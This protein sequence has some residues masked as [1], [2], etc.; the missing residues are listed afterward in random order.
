LSSYW[1]QGEALAEPRFRLARKKR[2]RNWM[3]ESKKRSPLHIL[4]GLPIAWTLS[5]KEIGD[6]VTV[7]AP[8]E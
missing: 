3:I 2:I 8:V 4:K 6:V 1:E 5:G 7:E